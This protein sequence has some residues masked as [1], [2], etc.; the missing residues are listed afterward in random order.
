MMKIIFCLFAFLPFSGLAQKL[1]AEKTV[2]DIGRMGWKQPVTAIFEFRNKSSRK[3]KILDVKPDCY[4]T[5]VDYP[6]GDI[7]A[8][9]QFQIRMT[10]DGGQLGHF[11]KQ[12]AVFSNGSKKPVYIEMRGVVLEH[13]VDLSKDYPVN[14][15]DLRL[16]KNDLEFDDVN[17]GDML[18]DE[19]RIYNNGTREYQPNLMHLPAYLTAKVTPE[20]LASGETGVITVTLNSTKLRD[21]G[22]T[23]TVLYLAGNPGDK[24]SPEHEIGASVVLL[25]AFPKVKDTNSMPKL[26][27]SKDSIDVRFEGK[28]KRTETIDIVNVGHAELNITSLQMFTPGLKISLGKSRL[29]PGESTKLKVTALRSELQKVRTRPRILMITDD[30]DKSKVTIHINTR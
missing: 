25:P 17:R 6:K 9:E 13:Y 14:M 8:N 3:L 28:D 5:W 11:D 19:L 30:P 29:K 10:Y 18:V 23:Q 22:L 20:R 27:L 4:C 24:V 7:G 26:Q 21:Y 1:V 12:A 15:G 2:V 16:S